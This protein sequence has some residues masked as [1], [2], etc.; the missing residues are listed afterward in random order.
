MYRRIMVP[1]DGSSFGDYALPAAAELARRTGAVLDLVHVHRYRESDPDGE[2][3]TPYQFEHVVEADQEQDGVEWAHEL[4]RLNELADGLRR[5]QAIQVFAQVLH[6][7]HVARALLTHAR[8]TGV[9]FVV[10]TTHGHGGLRP[11]GV[12][13]VASHLVHH[14]DVPILVMRP[15]SEAPDMPI[16]PSFQHVLVPLDGTD[17]SEEVLPAARE[18]AYPFGSSVTLLRVIEHGVW[19]INVLEVQV[20]DVKRKDDARAYLDDVA[21]RISPMW[22]TPTIAITTNES[23]AAGILDASEDTGADLIAM[24]THGRTGVSRMVLG[25]VADEVLRSTRL[26]LLLFGPAAVTRSH[27]IAEA[28]ERAIE[29]FSI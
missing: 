15:S 1:L 7:G 10:M 4:T 22:V 14:L 27:A 25:S 17:R 26:P 20:Q 23:A 24:A 8:E 18:L 29:A 19:P 21:R 13:S 2:G 5:A 28:T 12:G 6:G 9:D 16:A 3:L 11:F